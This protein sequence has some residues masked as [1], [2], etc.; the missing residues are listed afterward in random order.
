MSMTVRISLGHFVLKRLAY[1]WCFDTSG[2]VTGRTTSLQKCRT[3][4]PKVLLWKIFGEPARPDQV[5][6]G[7]KGPAKQKP[8]VVIVVVMMML[9][10]DWSMVV[11]LLLLLVMVLLLLL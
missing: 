8:K 6:C 9:V 4:N 10:V 2:W 3:S 11:V 5:I 7:K 1:F